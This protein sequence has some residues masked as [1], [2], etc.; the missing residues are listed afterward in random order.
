MI[1]FTHLGEVRAI[2]SSVRV[3][4]GTPDG[5]EVMKLL[6]QLSGWYDFNETDKDIIYMKH[7]ARQ[8]VACIK[9]LIDLKPEEIQAIAKQAV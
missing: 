3:L 7:G 2:Q 4:F 6:E 5:Q 8:L 1:H 9:N